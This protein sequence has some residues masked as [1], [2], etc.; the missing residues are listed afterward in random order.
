MFL[1]IQK[2]IPLLKAEVFQN[3]Q[4]EKKNMPLLK[5][6]T[7]PALGRYTTEGNINKIINKWIRS[8]NSECKAIIERERTTHKSENTNVVT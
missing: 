4:L 3:L 2:T 6:N 1:N 7:T 8:A 5:N